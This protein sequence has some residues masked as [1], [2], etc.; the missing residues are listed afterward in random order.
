MS[1]SG[2]QGIELPKG[3]KILKVDVQDNNPCIWAQ[4]DEYAPREYVEF[5][6]YATGQEIN[7][8]DVKYHD[9]VFLGT[10]VWHIFEV[11]QDV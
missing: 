6:M 4:V 1:L 10:T 9:T 3:Y 2:Y 8:S 5:Y 11:V 7:R